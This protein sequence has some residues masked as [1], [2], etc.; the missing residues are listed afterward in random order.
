[1]NQPC[2]QPLAWETLVEYWAGELA[3]DESNAVEEHLF[4]CA[5]CTAEAT[6]VAGVTEALRAALP[7]VISRRTLT[8][9]QSRGR[10]VR[11]NAFS[12]GERREVEFAADLDLLVHRLEGLALGDAEKVSFRI[13]SESTGEAIAELESAPFEKDEGAVLVACQRH[14]ATLPHDTVFD[15]AIHTR[16]GAIRTSSYTILHRYS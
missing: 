11:E 6:R 15:V 4:G 7:P 10:K 1:V 8:E 9:L 14:Y 13:R 2:G 12:P 16:G 3:T 5:A